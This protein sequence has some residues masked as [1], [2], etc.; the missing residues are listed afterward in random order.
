MRGERATT[1]GISLWLTGNSN[2]AKLKLM[3]EDESYV[4]CKIKHSTLVSYS[5]SSPDTPKVYRNVH[6][7]RS[8][9]AWSDCQGPKS[10]DKKYDKTT[11]SFPSQPQEVPVAFL[12]LRSRLRSLP[13]ISF[14]G[15]LFLR[16]NRKHSPRGMQGEQS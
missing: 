15:L 11:S 6:Q 3:A 12:R 5:T 13:L 16:A 1:L 2:T 9:L 4:C 10:V 14:H 8:S 7:N